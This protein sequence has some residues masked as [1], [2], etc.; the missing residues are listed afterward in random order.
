M[1][2]TILTGDRP[3]G[4]LHLG[5][6]VGS[7]RQRVELQHAH[8]QTILVA[9]LQGLT[10]LKNL[11][12][13]SK[14][15]D[16]KGTLQAETTDSGK[17]DR[18]IVLAMLAMLGLGV[19]FLVA[20]VLVELRAAEPIVP[21]RLFGNS[22]FTWSTLAAFAMN[23]ALMSIVIYVPVY[24]QGVLGVSATQSGLILI[25]M[26]VALFAA[27]IVIGQLTSRTGRYKEFMVGG[28]GVML[29]GALLASA[30]HA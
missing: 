14:L 9:D 3:T 27:G 6:F 30:R 12:V 7:L 29:V 22:V 8:N 26:N 11:D 10:D 4:S 24:A 19:V 17:V 18:Q 1:S 16:Y 2:Y 5:H 15:K 20:F 21:M 23:M 28:T 13:E 25:P